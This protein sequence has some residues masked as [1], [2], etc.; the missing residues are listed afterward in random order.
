MALLLVAAALLAGAHEIGRLPTH[1]KV[2]ALTF[3]AG[4]ND[5]GAW[6]AVSTLVHDHVTA[7]FFPTGRF[8]QQYPVLARQIG[9]HFAVG[10][11]TYSHPNLTGLPSALVRQEI[12]RGQLWIHKETGRDPRP[13]FR[14]PFGARDSR[15]IG[16]ARSLGYAD[17]YWST[18]TWGWM[19]RAQQS[20]TGVV[21]RV[22]TRV[23]PGE[24][25]LMH[26]GA[27]RDGSTLDTDALP[28][29]IRG[30]RARGYRFVRLDRWIRHA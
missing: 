7:T 23:Q 5:A 24:I 11:H 9:R 12:K 25:V 26:V 13:L 14:F 10:N 27:A 29:V 30:L 4:G 15:T 6:R 19:G 20:R 17:V 1:E 8:V 18:D 22:L 21:R 2:V 3:D 16:I 28:A